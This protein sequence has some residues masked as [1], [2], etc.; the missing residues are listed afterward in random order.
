MGRAIAKGILDAGLISREQMWAVSRS[1][2]KCDRATQEL[3]IRAAQAYGEDLQ[4]V[5]VLLVAVKPFQIEEVCQQIR[6]AGLPADTLLISVLAGVTTGR[7]ETTLGTSNP[8]IRSLPNTPSLISQG[9]TVICGSRQ[10]SP[11]HLEIAQKIFSAI[12]RCLV[13]EEKYFNAAT[14]ISGSGPAYMYLIIEALTDAGVQAGLQRHVAQQLVTQTMLGAAQMVLSSDRHPAELR[15][16]VTTPGGCTIA[17]LMKLEEGKI[18]SVLAQAVEE[19]TTVV[20]KLG[21]AK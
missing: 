10:A 4:K 8:W 2:A 1:R 17:G 14:A 12:G 3:G 20:G 15:G 6:E 13:L 16:D 11:H 21:S 5:S 7:L 19:A 9:M 18:R